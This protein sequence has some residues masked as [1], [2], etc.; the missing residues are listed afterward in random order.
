MAT[1]AYHVLP[2]GNLWKVGLPGNSQPASFHESREEAIA[3]AAVLARSQKGR[4]VVH[5]I[6]GSVEFEQDLGREPSPSL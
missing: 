4:I 1:L 3:R 5:R 6:D 2:H